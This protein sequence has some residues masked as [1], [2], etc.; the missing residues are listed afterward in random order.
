MSLFDDLMRVE[1]RPKRQNEA[2]FDYLNRSA[3]P[4]IAA[5]RF[6]F[7]DW[8]ARLPDF[9]KANLRARFRKR[10]EVS[11]QGAFFELFCHELLRR[12]SYEVE[13]HPTLANGKAPDFLV[14]RACVP[15]FYFEATLAANSEADQAA[16]RR[17]AVLHDTLDRMDSPDYF[18]DMEY[19]GTPEDNID[20]HALR[21]ALR[22]WLG[23]LDFNGVVRLS[24]DGRYQ[25][26]P[27]L[28]WRLGEFLLTFRPVPKSPQFR[29]QPGARSVGI[30]MP[31]TMR[32]LHT[33]DAIRAA[34]DRKAAKYKN[35][36]CPLVV[37]VN[38]MDDFCDDDDIYNA[39]FGERQ[40]VARRQRDGGWS[41]EE[42]R[43]P[44]GAWR[45][46]RGARS[47]GVSATIIVHQLVP[48][49]LRV[50]QIE[51]IHNPWSAHPL[52]TDLFSLPQRSVRLPGGQ[53]D[54]RPG[55]TSADVMGIP[56]PWPVPD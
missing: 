52:A 17:I 41:H 33:H 7:E 34:I 11:H 56:E 8:F 36:D 31:G 45:G 42:S 3:R 30:V 49:T 18:L 27:R 24:R 26:L 13:L 1:T 32:T 43:I 21:G 9:G 12:S 25:E 10:E 2:S 38:V 53:I 55:T 5:I 40:V 19:E 37:A 46:R 14:C 44:N 20:G 22:R 51:V 50:T 23:T 6:L 35:L 39:L 4:G 47:V 16:E 15:Q 54:R 48:T 29:D 28:N